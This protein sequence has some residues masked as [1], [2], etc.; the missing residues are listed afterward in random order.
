MYHEAHHIFASVNKVELSIAANWLSYNEVFTNGVANFTR[1]KITIPT[2]W[3][4]SLPGSGTIAKCHT[5]SKLEAVMSMLQAAHAN[6]SVNI[7]VHI[8]FEVFLSRAQLNFF[9]HPSIGLL[10]PGQT[11]TARAHF[12]TGQQW[13]MRAQAAFIQAQL[14]DMVSEMRRRVIL[15]A[16]VILTTNADTPISGVEVVRENSLRVRY[17]ISAERQQGVVVLDEGHALHYPEPACKSCD[18]TQTAL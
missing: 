3:S 15:P 4:I 12:P 7:R 10:A 1:L 14:A 5:A 18:F 16:N 9:G 17:R 2:R 11:F 8:F 6:S 13:E